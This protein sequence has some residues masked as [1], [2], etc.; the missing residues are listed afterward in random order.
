[1]SELIGKIFAVFA[2]IVFVTMLIK[3]GQIDFSVWDKAV[4]VTSEA[5]QSPS[6]QQ[7]INEVKDTSKEVGNTFL[8]KALSDATRTTL[9]KAILIRVVDGDTLYVKDSM[10]KDDEAYYVRLIGID[11]PESVNPDEEK[12]NDYGMAASEHTKELLKNTSVVYL[13]YDEAILDKY[14]RVLAYVWT[15]KDVDKSNMQDVVNY[16]L[17][18]RILKDG[19]A[20]DKVYQPNVKYADIFSQ[21]CEESKEA[22]A[23][24][25]A[26][27]G[28]SE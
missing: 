22:K 2:L 21:I 13:Q 26:D 6:G 20:T 19:Y 18:A 11:T 23:G 10:T 9:H 24:L 5:I 7:I 27:P 4:D 8:K 15:N 28:F 3:H 17:N 1:M 25:W 12:N 14:D 16:M